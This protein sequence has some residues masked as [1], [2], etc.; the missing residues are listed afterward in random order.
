[1]KAFE[2]HTYS[3]GNWKIDSVFD[4][5]ELA[6]YEARRVDDGILYSSVRVIEEDYDDSSDLTTTR[7]IF[8]GGTAERIGN[9]GYEKKP[10][11]ARA[12]TPRRAASR[13]PESKGAAGAHKITSNLVIPVLV[14]RSYHSSAEWLDRPT[15]TI[16]FC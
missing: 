8:R 12:T 11:K 16:L 13:E 15:Q 9:Q 10:G 7:T 14:F 4:N 6:L 1:M 3:D 2:L 5:R